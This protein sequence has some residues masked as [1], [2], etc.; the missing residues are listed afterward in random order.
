MIALADFMIK[1]TINDLHL[2]TSYSYVTMQ[3]NAILTFFVLL[4]RRFKISMYL[5]VIIINT[6]SLVLT[7]GTK[8]G[9]DKLKVRFLISNKTCKT[10]QYVNRKQWTSQILR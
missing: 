1:Q 2:L 10:T 5:I 4:L 9:L 8:S 3:K 7:T 6:R